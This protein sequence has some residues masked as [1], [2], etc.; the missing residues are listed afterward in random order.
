MHEDAELRLLYV[1]LKMG[2]TACCIL[3]RMI[4]KA[5]RTDD[6][7]RKRNNCDSEVPEHVRG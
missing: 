4:Q 1:I 3:M 5:G 6:L 2:G 7:R